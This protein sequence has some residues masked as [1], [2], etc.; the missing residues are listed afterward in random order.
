[1]ISRIDTAVPRFS[2]VEE[3]PDREFGF[4]PYTVPDSFSEPLPESELAVWER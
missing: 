2:P 4:V 1:M 3:A